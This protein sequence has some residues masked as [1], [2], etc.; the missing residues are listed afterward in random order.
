MP[1]KGNSA[2]GIKDVMGKGRSSIIQE[3]AIN[4][5]TKSRVKWINVGWDYSSSVAWYQRPGL[6]IKQ[7]QMSWPNDNGFL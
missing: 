7:N 1:I 4:S 2:K 6:D 3:Q 5:A